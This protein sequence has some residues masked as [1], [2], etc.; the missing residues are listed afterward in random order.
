MIQ[1]PAGVRQTSG[2][3]YPWYKAVQGGLYWYEPVRT[4]YPFWSLI[5]D[6]ETRGISIL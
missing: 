6:S 5:S 2:I 4:F 1:M 3:L